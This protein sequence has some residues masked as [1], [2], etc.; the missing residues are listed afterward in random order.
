MDIEQ[1]YS[2]ENDTLIIKLHINEEII[3]GILS[4]FIED[5]HESYYSYVSLTICQRGGK[6]SRNCN[7]KNYFLP[8]EKIYLPI[9]L[10][11]LGSHIFLF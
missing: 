8:N 7:L 4:T 1:I 2:I 11:T 10:G 9:N 5:D 6:N 3:Q